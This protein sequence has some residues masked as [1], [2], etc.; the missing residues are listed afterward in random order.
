MTELHPFMQTYR[1]AFSGILRWPQLDELWETLRQQTDKQWYIYAVGDKQL[2]HY[3]GP[4]TKK[5]IAVS[6]MLITASRQALSRSTIPIISV[7]CAVS[8]IIHPYLAG[9]CLSKNRSIF[10]LHIPRPAI[11]VVGG[12]NYSVLKLQNKPDLNG[13]L[14]NN[15]GFTLYHLFFSSC[16]TLKTL[17]RTS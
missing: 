13:R 9:F 12:K 6:C 2:T 8:V 5:I 3:C 17:H 15:C 10:R 7:S 4:N 16:P 11:G 14:I 1:G